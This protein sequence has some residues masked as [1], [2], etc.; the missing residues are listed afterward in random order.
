MNKK[1]FIN[2]LKSKLDILENQ[3]IEDII[4]E[5]QD[6][7]E[8]KVNKG[9]TEEEAVEEL[10]NIDEIVDDL[11]GAY[12][13]KNKKEKS[14]SNI[15]EQIIN[16]VANFVDIIVN[17]IKGK[18]ITD[19]FKFGFS[20]AI[21]FLFILIAKL[22]FL[23]IEKGGRDILNAFNNDF[24]NF[25]G[26]AWVLIIE[27]C[28]LFIAIIAFINIIEKEFWVNDKECPK[29]PKKLKKEKEIKLEKIKTEEL[30][31]EPSNHIIDKFFNI[32]GK[33][34]VFFIKFI[35]F[36]ILIC[37]AFYIVFMSFCFSTL[38]ILF[39]D[40][41][42]Y[43]GI[44]VICLSLLIIG[45]LFAELL[46]KLMVN[47]PN[48]WKRVFIS[49]VV[50]L[51][52]LGIGT[53]LTVKDFSDTEFRKIENDIKTVDE[54]YPMNNK[55]IITNFYEASYVIDNKVD[56]IKV[57][58]Q[59]NDNFINYNAYGQLNDNYLTL[60]LYSSKFDKKTFDFF[61]NGLKNK[62]LYY[63]D[64]ENTN[65][66]VITVN[67]QNYKTLKENYTRYDEWY[68]DNHCDCD[69]DIENEIE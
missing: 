52:F 51:L 16:R 35:I 14:N 1:E 45:I 20:L 42:K 3:E 8:E 50:C 40:G 12:K 7:I 64:E 29:T 55:L 19:I 66:I 61:I 46:F 11:L 27:F 48:N 10:G 59:Y 26:E 39:I 67:E 53:G 58:Y 28:Y 18:S 23:L 24:T 25:L 34:C 21:I 6:Y 2:A 41:F 13:I 60:G 56:N 62:V 31:S 36:W 32:I 65:S 33:A 5:Y 69:Y 44:G 22:P 43:F 54:E 63:Y 47:K 49:M 17:N 57:T 9:M 4:A 38:V 30:K 15:L 68:Y 37:I